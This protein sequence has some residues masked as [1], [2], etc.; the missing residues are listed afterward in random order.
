MGVAVVHMNINENVVLQQDV[1]ASVKTSGL[2]GD[3]YIKLTPGGDPEP[4]SDGGAI[5]ETES[6]VDLENLISKY[7]FGGVSD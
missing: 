3:K 5:S 4:I 7:V 1:I 2:I 6:A